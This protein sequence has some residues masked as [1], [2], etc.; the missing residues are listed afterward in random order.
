MPSSPSN[1]STLP[2]VGPPL[3]GWSASTSTK[4]ACLRDRRQQKLGLWSAVALQQHFTTTGGQ[5]GRP[6]PS[7]EANGTG[8]ADQ[9]EKGSSTGTHAGEE[10]DTARVDVDLRAHLGPAASLAAHPHKPTLAQRMGLVPPPPPAPSADD[11]RVAVH[12][13]M[14]REQHQLLLETG[15]GASASASSPAAV[16]SICQMSFLATSN[17]GQVILS[18]SHVFHTQCF[19][20][21]ERCVRAQQRADG[22]AVAEV[23]TQL[24]CP[25][26]RTRHYYKRVFYEGKA[27]TQRAAI[28][29]VQS[30]IRAFL[31]RRAYVQVRLRS[32]AQ[33]R[34][35][36]VQERLAR[37]SAA[38]SAFCVQQE[39]RREMTLVALAVQHQAATAAYLSEEQWAGIWERAVQKAAEPS[40]GA[41]ADGSGAC[42]SSNGCSAVAMQCPICLERIC[43]TFFSRPRGECSTNAAGASGEDAVAALRRAYEQ[44]RA[45]KQTAAALAEKPRQTPRAPKGEKKKT[46]ERGKR[47]AT[48]MP[49]TMAK[50]T[51]SASTT[52]THAAE[53]SATPALQLPSLTS[54]SSSIAGQ[55]AH[56]RGP[57]SGV[58]LSCGHCFH[59]ACL[60]CYERFNEQRMTEAAAAGSND[61][62]A[63][64]VVADRCPICR[65]GYAKHPL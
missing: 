33:F 51:S 10:E 23:T 15:A 13:A 47:E 6:L 64:V 8:S 61:A 9:L 22:A 55:A 58:L 29:K 46:A 42:S 48:R 56:F 14:Q 36:Y 11:W 21:F 18:C 25:V 24:A 49:L 39:R 38:W 17:E 4:R 19:R 16:C 2:S 34:T 53:G 54:P 44:R 28:V 5:R 63:G 20:A 26:C 40:N 45:A 30:A 1:S 32:N 3:S 43:E 35:R 50:A 41:A 60:G 27:M 37:L 57:Q 65:A 12:R 59:A 62:G 7:D 31:A 52:V